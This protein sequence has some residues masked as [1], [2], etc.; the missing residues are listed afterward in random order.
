[1]K[2]GVWISDPSQIKEEFLNFFKEKFKDHDPIVDFPPFAK[3]SGLCALDR[4]ILETLVSLDEV[5]NAVWDFG[6]SKAH[7]PDRLSIAFVKKYWDDNKVDILET[8]SGVR[9]N[10]LSLYTIWDSLQD[11]TVGLSLG[12]FLATCH[13]KDSG[14]SQGL[15]LCRIVLRYRCARTELITPNLICPSTHQL[16]RS[17]SGDSGPDISF[18]KS[19]SPERLFSLARVSLAGVSK[20]P[21]SSGCSEGD[22]TSSCP[23][24]V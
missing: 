19:A 17:S 7:G 10:E 23:P 11:I 4:D 6:S 14:S 13:S 12:N 24:L 9:G 8:N 22:Y 21:F 1:M 16:L 5:K 18:D 15:Y 3:S 2:E 20:L